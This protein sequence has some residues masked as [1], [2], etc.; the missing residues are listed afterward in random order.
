LIHD[1]LKPFPNDFLWGAASAAYQ[2]EGAWNEDGKGLSIWDKFVRIPGK[3]FKG[4]NGDVAVDHYHRYKEDIAL[5]AEMGL[6]AY[7]FSVSWPRIFPKGKGEINRKGLEFYN[8]V[9]NELKKNNIEPILTIYHWDLP[10]ALQDEYGGWESREIVEDFRNYCVTLFK[11]FGDRVKY[12]VTLNEQNI[13]TRFGYQTAMHPPGLK[14]PK[15]FYQVNHHANLAN[16]I[17]IKEFRKYVPDGKIGPSF[18]Y[19]PAYAT[20]SKPE[21]IIAAENAEEFLS[22]WWLD[23]YV[24]G[25]YPKATWNYLTKAGLA[26]EVY[27]SDFEL[28]KEGKPD[29]IGVNYYQS[30]TFEKNP[31][32]GV[33]M[34]GRFNNTGKKGTMEDT[35]IPGLFK[36]VKNDHLERTNWDWNIDPQGLRIALRRLTNRYGLPILISENGLGEY[37]KVEDGAIVDDYRIDYIRTHIKAIQEAITDGTEVLGY[38]IWSFTDLLSWLNGFQK[39]YGLVYVNQ[40]EEGEHDLRRMKKKS[41]YWYKEIIESNGKNL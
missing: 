14:D 8:N 3:T 30:T 13:F 26:P 22:H 21:D 35:G 27:E 41:F 20:T 16:A 38:C 39:R 11:E 19:S 18:A 37:D 15:L 17:A 36:T 10:Q 25:T 7:R 40:H 1:Q 24:W 23:V 12:W 5:M 29:F 34:E 4:T 33:T 2:V 9:I 31:L 32:D 28:L 6:K